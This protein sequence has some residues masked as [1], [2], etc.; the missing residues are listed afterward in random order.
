MMI[1]SLLFSI[2]PSQYALWAESAGLMTKSVWTWDY[3]RSQQPLVV[4]TEMHPLKTYCIRT[5]LHTIIFTYDFTTEHQT[6]DQNPTP[7]WYPV[8]P[9]IFQLVVWT[10]L[11][12]DRGP[13]CTEIFVSLSFLG[14]MKF[15]PHFHSNSE[16][17]RW[18]APSNLYSYRRLFLMPNTWAFTDGETAG[19]MLY[20][21][22][23]SKWEGVVWLSILETSCTRICTYWYIC[24]HMYIAIYLHCLHLH[25]YVHIHKYGQTW[26]Y[27]ANRWLVV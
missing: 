24:T 8:S 10:Q 1:R 19:S 14:W 11:V 13:A 9:T 18:C 7:F 25:V 6:A 15:R 12:T 26:I 4:Q 21:E 2:P 5:I 20:P 17:H 23:Q 3:L 27:S 22:R 16:H